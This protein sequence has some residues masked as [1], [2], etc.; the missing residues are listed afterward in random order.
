[1]C[2]KHGKMRV[3]EV[4]VK[5]IG[6][7]GISLD[8]TDIRFIRALGGRQAKLLGGVGSSLNPPPQN[9]VEQK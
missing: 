6:I 5:K 7:C 1:M 8:Y 9:G 2:W 3:Q 4:F